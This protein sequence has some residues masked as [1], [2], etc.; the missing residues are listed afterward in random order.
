MIDSFLFFTPFLVLGIIAL[1]GFVGCDLVFGLQHVPDPV[2]APTGL[3]ATAG[4]GRVDLSWD[5]SNN[6]K[7]YQLNKGTQ[8]GVY[9]EGHV[10]MA[11]GTTYPDTGLTNGTEYFYDLIVRTTDGESSP[12]G[13]VSA[14]PVARPLLAFVTSVALGSLRNQLTAWA[15]MTIQIGPNPVTVQTLGRIFAAG[16]TVS[17]NVKIVDSATSLDLAVVSVN[18]ATGIAGQFVY[19]SL[20]VPLILSAGA[21]YHVVSEEVAGG[22]HLYLSDTVVQ[23]TAVATVISAVTGTMQ[24]VYTQTDLPGH[25][26]GPVDFQY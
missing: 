20:T 19:T 15:G 24:G 11:P 8:T 9:N 7:E 12:S 2:P 22:D 14:T 17:H 16:N 13:E 1:L 6:A 18:V 21:I 25:T 5:A 23:T 3:T 10:I 4:D 26:F